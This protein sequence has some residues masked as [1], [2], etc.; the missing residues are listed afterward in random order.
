MILW[1][2][3]LNI[4]AISL[5]CVSF[6]FWFVGVVYTF[7]MS[8][9]SYIYTKNILNAQTRELRTNPSNILDGICHSAHGV[10]THIYLEI[11][12]CHFAWGRWD[13][14]LKLCTI[15]C[16]SKTEKWLQIW[17]QRDMESLGKK[18]RTGIC[19]PLKSYISLIIHLL[20]K[21]VNHTRAE[22][23][24]DHVCCPNPTCWEQ[25]WALNKNAKDVCWMKKK[26]IRVTMRV[27]SLRE[28]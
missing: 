10:H 27:T 9:V 21:L 2:A 20:S 19:C 5:G 23:F 6:Y 24:A 16:T 18:Q 15:T 14:F 28:F 26:M 25:Y 7:W 8:F 17:A 11:F 13:L 12:I 1:S 22:I 3:F 4:L